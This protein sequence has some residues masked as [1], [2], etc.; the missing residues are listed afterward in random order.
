MTDIRPDRTIL[1]SVLLVAAGFIALGTGAVLSILITAWADFRPPDRLSLLGWL[2]LS[3][4]ASALCLAIARLYNYAAD[5][6]HILGASVD[7]GTDMQ[8]P[9]LAQTS[10][11]AETLR[12][13]C[14]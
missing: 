12:T 3:A 5:I 13:R 11:T 1:G 7:T 10:E 4:L 14:K 6:W 2:C 8:T 9:V